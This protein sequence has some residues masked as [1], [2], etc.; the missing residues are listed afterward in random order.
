MTP[1]RLRLPIVPIPDSHGGGQGVLLFATAPL[2]NDYVDN[3]WCKCIVVDR[4]GRIVQYRM[5]H[6]Q[7]E[8]HMRDNCVT[9]TQDQSGAPAPQGFLYNPNGSVLDS[10]VFSNRKKLG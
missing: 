9:F 2:R 3:G 7:L 1:W 10:S 4:N 8:R 6:D 5:R